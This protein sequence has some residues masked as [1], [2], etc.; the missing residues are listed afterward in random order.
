MACRAPHIIKTLTVMKITTNILL[1]AALIVYVFLPLFNIEFA[2][3]ITGF[4]YSSYTISESDDLL[5]QLF[6]LLPFVSCFGA[7][8]LNCLKHRYWGAGVAVLIALGLAF[9]VAAKHFVLIQMPDVYRYAGIGI[10]FN[11]SYGLM[12]CALASSIIS[13]LPFNFNL[14]FE[15]DKM[16]FRI[17]HKG[18]NLKKD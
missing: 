4:S 15:L 6:A 8:A 14:R 5:K 11:I 18:K 7:I 13:L 17:P 1:V 12:I 3:G 2:G 16:H 9:Y 10:G